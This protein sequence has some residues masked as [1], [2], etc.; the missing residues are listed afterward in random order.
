MIPFSSNYRTSDAASVL[1]VTSNIALAVGAKSGCTGIA[2][3]GG[4]GT[5][6]AQAIYAAQ[7]ALVAKQSTIP[8]SQNAM[9]ILSDG[10]AT[11]SASSGQ[12]VATTGT[13]NGTGS[14]SNKYSYTYPSAQGECGQAVK[15]AIDAATNSAFNN[16]GSYTRIYTVGY[17]APT[18]GGCTSDATYSGTYTGGGGGWKP[19]DQPCAALAAMASDSAY[20]FSDDGD[21]CASPNGISYTKLTQIFQAI[22]GN[23]TTPRLI[24]NGTT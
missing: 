21:K 15:A 16:A 20:F 14:G 9:I 2:A 3:P 11:A 6:Y 18:S 8:G 22:A 19:G 10:N 1:D 4:E 24:P 5:Y 7:A 13:L 17:G 23:L 12:I